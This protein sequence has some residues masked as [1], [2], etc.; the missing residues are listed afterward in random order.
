MC[1]GC[2]LLPGG[3][4]SSGG[5]PRWVRRTSVV[6]GL[7]SRHHLA[8]IESAISH[9]RWHVSPLRGSRPSRP[10]Q[11]RH[12]SVAALRPRSSRSKSRATRTGC[13]FSRPIR[14]AIH[15]SISLIL[16]NAQFCGSSSLSMVPGNLAIL[17]PS[18]AAVPCALCSLQCRGPGGA[19]G[20]PNYLHQHLSEGLAPAYSRGPEPPEEATPGQF[21]NQII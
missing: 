7:A 13:S 21:N 11:K 14:P 19:R 9:L 8:C 6:G 1:P 17:G 12:G 5:V 20:Q 15:P 18:L 10:R 16:A 2:P 3:G 4:L